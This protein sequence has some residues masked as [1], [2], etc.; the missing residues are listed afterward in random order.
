MLARICALTAVAASL[1]VA[2]PAEAAPA[3]KITRIYYDSPGSDTRTNTSL[4]GE[5]VIVK[6]MTGTTRSITGWTVKD[7]A[8]HTYKFGTF[9]LGA[10]K[11]VVLR[12]GKGANTSTTRYWQL[13]SYV[14]N[15]DRD[16]GT[17]RNAAGT[18]IH[19]CAYS[20]TAV[21]YKNC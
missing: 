5:Y 2:V 7:V 9:S 11:T 10:Y 4:N 20:S 3:V 6:N 8:G 1:L 13:T 21:D 17:L 19:S 16:T 18:V 15:N 12:T 14:W